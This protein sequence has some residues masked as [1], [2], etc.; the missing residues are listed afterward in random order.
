[1][2]FATLESFAVAYPMFR[3]RGHYFAIA[4]LCVALVWQQL[5]LFWEWT[6][7][8]RGVELPIKPTPNFTYMQFG[9][10]GHHYFI[11]GLFMAQFLF[12]NWFRKSKLGYQLQAVRDSEDA[13]GS[14]GINVTWTK[15]KAYLITAAMGAMGGSFYAA[16]HLYID[17]RSVMHIDL[18]ILIAMTAMVGGSGSIWGPIIGAAMLIPL[19]MYLAALLGGKGFYGIDFMIYGFIIMVIAA[20][21]PRGI[22]G[23]IERARG[24]R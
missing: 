3:L 22:W 23:I 7:A 2:F 6:G 11:F 16:Y 9:A 21:E 15:V 10:F 12:M 19:D 24:R 20:F 1:M 13:G 17:P 14:L 5:F 18:T 8:A 4:T